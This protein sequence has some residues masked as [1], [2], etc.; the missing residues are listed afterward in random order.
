MKASFVTV[1]HLDRKPVVEQE[2]EMVER[3]GLGHPDYI[4]DSACEEASLMLSHYYVSKY[5]YVLHHNVDKG[6][7]IGGRA[8]NTFGYGRLEEPITIIIAG[9]AS[10]SVKTPTGE[11]KIPYKEIITDAVRSMIKR[12]FRFLD[13]DSHV[14]LEVRVRESSP[15][16]KSVVEREK[17]MPLANDTSYGVAFYPF[18]PLES[19][20]LNVE[21]H[22]NS[23]SFKSRVKE[24]GEDVKVMGLRKGSKITVTVADGIVSTLT[25]DREHYISVKEQI[26]SEVEDL[27]SR[28]VGDHDVTVYVNTADKYGTNIQNEIFYLTFTGT[29]AEHGDDGNTGRGNRANGLITPNRQMSLEATAGK[30][31][32]SHVGKIYNVC[33][34]LTARR[35]YEETKRLKEVYV[36]MLSQIGKPI[37]QPLSVSVQAIPEDK[38]DT[39]LIRDIEGIVYDE[40]ANIRK[41]TELI[42]A[43]KVSVF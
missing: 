6:L 2:I 10:T 29:S 20:V 19:L 43:R 24:S 36:R 18:T 26:K 41:V 31:P 27:A 12:N 11:E 37:N 16:L 39:G 14:S 40:V 5:G 9:R 42:L 32:I 13:F 22:L 34:G 21:R 1:E 30:N 3:K 25:R 15:D 28:I 33:A 7:L 35:I 17:E 23:P 4:I 8:Y 38:M